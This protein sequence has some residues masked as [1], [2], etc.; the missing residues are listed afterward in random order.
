[1]I[2]ASE[3]PMTPDPRRKIDELASDI[4]DVASTA[5]DLH[6]DPTIDAHVAELERL[7]HALAQASDA[8]DE[9]DEK[10]DEQD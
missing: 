9:L 7:Q 2:R 4:D 6:T 10:V 8:A 1:M 3:V 5:E